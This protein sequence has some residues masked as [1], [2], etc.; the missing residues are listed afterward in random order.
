MGVG[1]WKALQ[2]INIPKKGSNALCDILEERTGTIDNK[3]K[4]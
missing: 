2:L 3:A 1:T 4:I